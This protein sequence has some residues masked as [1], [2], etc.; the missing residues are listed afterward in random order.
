MTVAEAPVVFV[1][2]DGTIN[3]KGP[4]YGYVTSVEQFRFRPGAVAGLELLRDAGA[5]VIVVTNQRAVALGL[6][7]EEALHAMHDAM[8]RDL[9]AAI[10][11]CPHDL[12]ACDCRKPG[13][14]MFEAAVRDMPWIAGRPTFVVGDSHVDIEAAERMGWPGLLVGGDELPSLYDAAR[15]ILGLSRRARTAAAG[16]SAAGSW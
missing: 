4:G 16:R 15:S 14:G 13:T 8:L 11:H 9:V 3:E 1:D 7:S 10:Y 6:L 12:D 2:R 5:T